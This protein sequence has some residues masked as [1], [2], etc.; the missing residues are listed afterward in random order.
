MVMSCDSF[1]PAP[2]AYEDSVRVCVA[3]SEQ[4]KAMDLELSSFT[5]QRTPTA[6]VL[7]LQQT[8][9]DADTRRRSPRPEQ[10]STDSTHSEQ[11]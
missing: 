4:L 8:R 11:Q 10:T 9:R 1:P 6:E 2:A 3:C 5:R 7:A